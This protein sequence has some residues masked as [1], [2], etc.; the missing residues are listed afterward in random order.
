[1]K[2]FIDNGLVAAVLGLFLLVAGCASY[3]KV[4]DPQSGNVYYT[5]KV[6]YVSGGAVRM[7]DARTGSMVTIQNSEVK[8]ISSDEYKAG[9]AAPA[10]KPTPAGAP[11][12]P[13]AA[14]TPATAPAA[15]PAP[16]A[17]EAPNSAPS[18]T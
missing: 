8:E 1:M 16:T 4:R 9:L 7:M 12:A 2:R 13:A 6:D 18:G 5:Q 10:A 15:V 14:P 11:A 17:T 3:Y